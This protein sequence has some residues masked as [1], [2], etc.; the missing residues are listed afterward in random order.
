MLSDAAS[1]PIV[2]GPRVTPAAVCHLLH[3]AGSFAADGFVDE[4]WPRSRLADVSG[5]AGLYLLV[6]GSRRVVRLGQ[7][8]RI[9]GVRSRIEEHLARPYG[10]LVEHAWVV[11]VDELV[12]RQVL[13]AMEGRT[14][15]LL[16]VRGTMGRF[17][18]PSGERWWDLVGSQHGARV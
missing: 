6:D 2:L 18:W 12:D 9:H 13:N 16:G 14:A 11:E 17:R 8:N 4:G 1:P 7:A 3:A 15:D 10:V 5:R